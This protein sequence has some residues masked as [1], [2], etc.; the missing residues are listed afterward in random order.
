[1][2]AHSTTNSTL[3]QTVL[4]IVSGGNDQEMLFRIR[5][6]HISSF[7]WDYT[8]SL[9][10]PGTLPS[11]ITF[12]DLDTASGVLYQILGACSTWVAD[13]FKLQ[14][15]PALQQTSLLVEQGR[16]IA[17]ISMWLEQFSAKLTIFQDSSDGND[18]H[19]LRMRMTCMS[20]LIRLSHVLDQHETSYDIQASRFEQIVVDAEHVMSISKRQKTINSQNSADDR[21]VLGTG[22]VEPLFLV[23]TKYSHT[24]WR[25]RAIVCLENA[26]LELPF[27]GRREEAIARN[28]MDYELRHSQDE[29]VRDDFHPQSNYSSA[30]P[31]SRLPFGI[32]EQSRIRGWRIAEDD[33]VDGADR[34]LVTFVRY[35]YTGCTCTCS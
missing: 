20:W 1:M 8:T 5:D 17:A 24:P 12:S 6:V 35:K 9:T 18:E 10:K 31:S 25:R 29:V 30:Q 4:Q 7:K 32:L 26:G 2:L 21:C 28:I 3:H 11:C 19:A 16:H 15:F 27:N 34:V 22:L 23:A 13:V 33:F 14:Y